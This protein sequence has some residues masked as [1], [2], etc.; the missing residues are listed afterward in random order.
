MIEILNQILEQNIIEEQ[1]CKFFTL[2]N[3]IT[4]DAQLRTFQYKIIHRVLPTNKLICTYKVRTEPWCEKCYNIIETLE[5]L[6]HLHVCP[7]KWLYGTRW[8][9]GYRQ[10]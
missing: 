7:E 4:L 10:N 9:I 1:W 2:T 3:K 6:F 5:H 8:R